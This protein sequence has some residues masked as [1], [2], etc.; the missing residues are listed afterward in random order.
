MLAALRAYNP[1]ILRGLIEHYG[2]TLDNEL[3][4]PSARQRT[5]YS[6][7][8]TFQ[9]IQAMSLHEFLTL[10]EAVGADPWCV[11]P[12]VFSP[13]EVTN[14]MEYLGGATSTT[15]G[16][17]RAALGHPAPWTSVFARIHIEFG[18]ENWNAVFR[19]GTFMNAVAYGTR[20]NAIFGTLKSSPYYNSAQFDL[21]LG[22]QAVNAGVMLQIHN[23]SANHDSMTL[24]P[25]MNSKVDTFATNEDYYGPLFAEPEWWTR[26]PTASS[27]FM[28]AN[29]NSIQGSSRPVPLSVYEVN[30]N[31]TQ[32]AITQAA[33]D[34]FV[35]STG[36]GLALA[37]HMLL[38]LHDLGMRDQVMFSLGGY[39]ANRGDGKSVALWGTVRDMGVTDRKRPQFLALQM[40]N[41]ALAG[42]MVATTHTG[43][44]PTWNQ[45]LANLIAY[46]GAHYL[47]SYAFSNGAGKS[48][49]VFNLH[50]TSSLG[51][52]FTGANAP[53]GTIARQVLTSANLTDNNES[54]LNV[55]TVT[56][57]LTNFD[58]NA[59]LT[60]PA[61]S[62]TLLKWTQPAVDAWRY[63]FFGTTS[64]TGNAANTADPFH[65]GI[66]NLA[67]F[68]LLGPS[69]DPAKV[70]SALLPKPQTIGTNYVLSFT[71]PAGVSGVTYGAEWRPDL[72]TGTWQPMTDAGSGSVH[73]FSVPIGSNMKMFMR[74]TV[75]SP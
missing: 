30:I 74:L 4:V 24:A 44:D 10:C 36:S 28:R 73:T 71:Q 18:N 56:D 69:Q 33:L 13:Q 22:A 65:T 29:Y 59:T 49:I 53:A 42:N 64:N 15:Y 52:N 47:Q 61:F 1:G 16:A 5:G 75:T 17:K 45:P 57:T 38:M 40:A 21:V 12:T 41:Q 58:P 34:S 60:L 46:T 23:A 14:L 72:A 48:L 67:V 54:A 35:P 2:D 8:G 43:D 63:T 50:R 66:P 11:M 31:T 39:R 51:V 20:G 68:G 32:G 19:G 27:G 9:T 62:M 37:D 26:N 7:F 25:Y 55:A 6:V 3:S 70:A